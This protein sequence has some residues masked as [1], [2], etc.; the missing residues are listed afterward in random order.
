MD[1]K[2]RGHGE[3]L[4]KK[5]SGNLPEFLLAR[6]ETDGHILEKARELAEV[7]C[8]FPLVLNLWLNPAYLLQFL[9][10]KDKD[11]KDFPDLR[12]ELAVRQPGL[13]IPS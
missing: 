11:L 3:L 8:A 7:R 10:E 13:N 12:R 2:R 9:I 4:G 6:Y 5:Q 1:L